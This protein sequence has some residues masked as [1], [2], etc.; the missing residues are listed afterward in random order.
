MSA[1]RHRNLDKQSFNLVTERVFYR[2]NEQFASNE[3][4]DIILLWGA[5]ENKHFTND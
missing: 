4:R 3:T 2:L 5:S 1:A